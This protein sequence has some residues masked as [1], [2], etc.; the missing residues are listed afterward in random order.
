MRQVRNTYKGSHWLEQKSVALKY[1]CIFFLEINNISGKVEEQAPGDGGILRVKGKQPHSK[2]H[3]HP[4]FS[5][6]QSV[7]LR[8]M[9]YLTL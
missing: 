2:R 8:A 4:L 5:A 6:E 7:C 9:S 1:C 3:G